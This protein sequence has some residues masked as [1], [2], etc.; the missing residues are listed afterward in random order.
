M[1]KYF[2]II[3]IINLCVIFTSC[4]KYNLNNNFC[5]CAKSENILLIDSLGLWIPNFI[6]PNGDG[7]ND[8]WAIPGIAYFPDCE[9]KI[10]KGG[11]TKFK[12]TGY[13]NSWPDKSIADGK[14]H[15]EITISNKTLKSVFCVYSSGNYDNSEFDCIHDLKPTDQ[16]DPMLQ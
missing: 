13:N 2:Y 6:S 1:K 10:S 3:L 4:K 12:T 8:K 15:Y 11:I 5:D 9:I 14:Y 16:G 7:K